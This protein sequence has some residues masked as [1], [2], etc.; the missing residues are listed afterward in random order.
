MRS[1]LLLAVLLIPA[2]G[3]DPSEQPVDGV[4]PDATSIRSAP[5]AEEPLVLEAPAE[6]VAE[7][8]KT[9]TAPEGPPTKISFEIAELG[10][11]EVITWA[12]AE[13]R[14][15]AKVGPDTFQTEVNRLRAE[16]LGRRR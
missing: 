14:A 5:V 15:T 7:L 11:F 6:P 13:R 2:C 1:M 10:R 4:S 3:G 9:P 8:E 12:E 16:I